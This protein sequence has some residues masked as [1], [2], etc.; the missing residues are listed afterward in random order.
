MKHLLTICLWLSFTLGLQAQN[1]WIVFDWTNS[2]LPGNNCSG[3]YAE[4]DGTMWIATNQGVAKYTLAGWNT[5]SL[6]MGGVLPNFLSSVQPDQ[7][8]NIWAGAFQNG[9]SS[10]KNGSWTNE[11]TGNVKDVHVDSINQVWIATSDQG[12]KYYDGSTWTNFRTNNTNGFNS[13][14]VNC[15]TDDGKGNIYIG[16]DPQGNWVGGMAKFDGTNWSR[17][18]TTLNNLPSNQVNR[19]AFKPDGTLLIATDAGLVEG[20][21]TNW[22]LYET[23]NSGIP[24]NLVNTVSINAAGLIFVGTEAGMATFDGTTWTV[25]N[26]SNS[27]LKDNRIREIAFDNTGHTWMATGAGVAIYKAGGATVGIDEPAWTASL[28]YRLAPSRLAAGE[29]VQLKLELPV[30]T[31]VQV[32]V[33]NLSGQWVA[34]QEATVLS[35]GNYELPLDTKGLSSGIYF[36]RL[37][38]GSVIRTLKMI[39]R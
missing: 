26:T 23:G 34:G 8:G 33:F 37:Q 12:V 2:S 14:V 18:T 22:T 32:S 9:I 27:G 39:I 15:L 35:A 11:S 20:S 24:S 31:E 38:M 29:A 30:R 19:I 4:D 6:P 10:Y 36:V 1:E 25:F 17:W 16:F 7:D 3:I 13:D 5:Y 28:T 21:G